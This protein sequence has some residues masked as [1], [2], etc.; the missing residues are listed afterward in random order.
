MDNRRRAGF[1]LLEVMAAV[2]LFAVLGI[3]CLDNYLA[4]LR[5]LQQMREEEACVLCSQQK[6]GEY[7]LAPDNFPESGQL[8]EPYANLTYRT[9]TDEDTLTDTGVSESSLVHRYRFKVKT[10]TVEGAHAQ[11]TIPLDAVPVENSA[12]EELDETKTGNSGT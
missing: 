12:Q 1:T 8:D 11:V 5:I 7:L 10:L 6:A 9:Q 3:A 2:A 4:N